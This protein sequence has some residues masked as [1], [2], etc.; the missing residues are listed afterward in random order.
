MKIKA[1][2]EEAV[3]GAIEAKIDY[4]KAYNIYKMLPLINACVI[5]LLATI[6]GFV[7]WFVYITELAYELEAG[8]FL[9]WFLIGCAVAGIT[10][11]A[12]VISISP[13]VVRTDALI[14]IQN[15]TTGNVNNSAAYVDE[16]PE[17]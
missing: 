1:F 10:Y 4:K 16:L 13:I 7:D 14:A 11:I 9:I 5:I 17:L 8:A 2:T 6:W 3:K 12:S 15:A